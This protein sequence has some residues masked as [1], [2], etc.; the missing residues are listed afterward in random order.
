MPGILATI[1]G[2][3]GHAVG[4]GDLPAVVVGVSRSI[5]QGDQAGE[6]VV[7]IYISNLQGH[8]VVMVG[9][10]MEKWWRSA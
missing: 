5:E 6:V 1:M 8:A 4:W 9:I 7:G 10:C 3:H 2:K